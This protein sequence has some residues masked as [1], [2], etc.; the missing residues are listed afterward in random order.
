LGV[1][2]F[3]ECEKTMTPRWLVPSVFALLVPTFAQ[4]QIE[5]NVKGDVDH[6]GP[7]FTALSD[8]RI[9]FQLLRPANVALLWVT[10][11][12]RID[13]FF[14]VRSRDKTLK[15]SGNNAISVSDIPSPIQSPVINGAP[16]SGR[17]G[18]FAPTG[19]LLTAPPPRE[20]SAH[21]SGYWVLLTADAPITAGEIQKKLQL[22]SRQGGGLSIIDRLAPVLV[23]E[24]T[25]WAQYV[26][27]VVMR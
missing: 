3:A 8:S 15:R 11:D 21:V 12:G 20:D 24:G 14:P 16:V 18:Q 6:F 5:Q 1:P 19:S 13:L 25:L 2:F 4:A 26:A 17:A 23:P 7:G 22:I 10:P 27:A 9:D